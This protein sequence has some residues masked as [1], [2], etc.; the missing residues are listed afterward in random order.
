MLHVF[1]FKLSVIKNYNGI[2]ISY[3]SHEDT[4]QKQ[5]Q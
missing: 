2:K 5:K 4:D 3:Y 1:T